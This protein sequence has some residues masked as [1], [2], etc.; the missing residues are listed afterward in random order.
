MRVLRVLV[1]DVLLSPVMFPISLVGLFG[2]MYISGASAQSQ[3]LVHRSEIPVKVG[4]I[5]NAP[6][7]VSTIFRD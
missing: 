4:E 7:G 2:W 5:R 3:E 1:L 6:S